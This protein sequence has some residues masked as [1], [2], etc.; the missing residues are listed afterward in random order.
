[1][2]EIRIAKPDCID[3]FDWSF[4]GLIKVL[5]INIVVIIVIGILIQLLLHW[6]KERKVKFKIMDT[7]YWMLILIIL[8]VGYFYIQS[9]IPK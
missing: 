6:I 3:C 7:L 9:A 4:T 5:S 2:N 8:E 1:M